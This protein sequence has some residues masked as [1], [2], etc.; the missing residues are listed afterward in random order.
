MPIDIKNSLSKFFKY[1][2]TDH[3]HNKNMKK[4]VIY[5]LIASLV[6]FILGSGFEPE[7]KD[8]IK[9]VDFNVP[10]GILHLAYKYD[11]ESINQEVHLDMCEMLAYLAAKN[12]NRFSK[13]D[14]TTLN[15]LVKELKTGI[16]TQD[17][18]KGNPKYYKY[19]LE[20]YRAIFAKF[21]DHY[22]T[23]DG[24]TGYGLV[25]YYPIAKGYG[26]SSYDDFG[27]SRSY[28]FKRR[29]LGHDM[30]GAT[31]TPII[32]VEGGT[33]TEFGWNRYG[34]WRIGIRSDDGKRFYY[35]AHLRRNR[36]YAQGLEKGSKVV[37][38]QVIGYMG[39]TGYSFQ[40]NK[41]MRTNPHLH[42]G[43]QLIFD[44]SQVRGNGEIWIDVN[45]ICKLL[46]HNRATT[47]K[48]NQTKEYKSINLRRA[49]PK[50][51]YKE[52]PLN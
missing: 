38:G 29:H 16:K 43:L 35:Y 27:N 32:A 5:L 36:P 48:D 8:Y 33:I 41:N 3:S 20:S 46:E 6:V 50:K 23:E 9:W 49:I 31:G 7:K 21:L 13:K 34:G 44:E 22:I 51:H 2:F 25:A 14:Y 26:V 17:L 42:F 39:A 37:A 28:G 12:G 47:V 15:Q 10:Y 18:I 24:Q 52:L 45:N 1:K 40:E 30:F 11:V 19:Y 4:S